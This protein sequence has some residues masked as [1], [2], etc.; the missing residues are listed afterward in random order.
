MKQGGRNLDSFIAQ[1]S[2]NELLPAIFSFF[3][4][5]S[6]AGSKVTFGGY[7]LKKYAK[8]GIEKKDIRWME[9]D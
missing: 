4:T 2:S 1:V 5:K 8:A 7:D 3:L 9:I 6:G